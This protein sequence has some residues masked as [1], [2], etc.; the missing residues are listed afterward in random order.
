MT[1]RVGGGL[2]E[3]PDPLA[4]APASP[5]AS[6]PA[7]VAPQPTEPPPPAP[8][9]WA[10]A[11]RASQTTEQRVSAS[12]SHRYVWPRFGW[13][14][15]PRRIN[16]SSVLE[17]VKYSLILIAVAGVLGLLWILAVTSRS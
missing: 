16:R 3:P 15:R 5:Q 1:E 2:L 14:N 13:A 9:T 7:P 10:A 6:A 12:T 8:A 17:T 4:S 11:A